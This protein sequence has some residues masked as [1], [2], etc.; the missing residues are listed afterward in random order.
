MK[1]IIVE[2]GKEFKINVRDISENDIFLDV[3]KQAA[4]RVE[5][6][7]TAT[8]NLKANET[9]GDYLNNIIAF[10]GERGQGK[11]SAMISFTEYLLNISK[12]ES[13]MGFG[14]NTKDYKFIKIDTIDPS[15][16]EDMHNILEMIIARMYNKFEEE[17]R[18]NNE[19]VTREQ[20]VKI[21]DMFQRVYENLCLIR[22][23]R[24]LEELEYDYEGSIQKIA[25]IGDST[26][27][28]ENIINLVK[29][30]LEIFAEGADKSFLVIPIDDLDINIK[31][32]YKIAEQI[33]KYLV[34]PNVIIIMAIK[35]EQ[36][37]KCVEKEFREQLSS[38]II[39]KNRIDND[40]PNNMA[41]KYVE[42]LIPDGRKINLP[43][44]RVISQS[45][46]DEIKL[47]YKARV[48][49]KNILESDIRRGIEETLLGYIYDKTKIIFVK[50]RNSVHNIIPNT[51]R[52]VVNLLSVLGKM[53]DLNNDEENINQ[54]ENIKLFEEYFISTWVPNNLDDGNTRIVRELLE[55]N[56]FEKH[57]LIC[58][59]IMDIIE[60][61]TMYTVDKKTPISPLNETF[62]S[63]KNK[64]SKKNTNS[65]RYSL[66]DVVDLLD[67][68]STRYINTQID[69]FIFAIKTIYTILMN[70]IVLTETEKYNVF[71]PNEIYKF[72]G[73][74]IWG[75]KLNN[76]MRDKRGS[77]IYDAK[78]V[79]GNSFPIN[80]R[81][82]NEDMNEDMADLITRITLFSNF[83][84]VDN[85]DVIYS[86]KF[87]SD[88]HQVKKNPVLSIDN[89]FIAPLD[90]RYLHYKSGLN[91]LDYDND[92]YIDE[93]QN[94]FN[95]DLLRQIVINMELSEYIQQYCEEN[96]GIKY[97]V[98][99]ESEY[100]IKFVD[101]VKDA[102]NEVDYINLMEKE[103]ISNGIF[104]TELFK[105]GLA[106]C[107]ALCLSAK[108][109]ESEKTNEKAAK[110]IN[111]VLEGTQ[112]K[113]GDIRLI[114]G[115]CTALYLKNQALNLARNIAYHENTKKIIKFNEETRNKVQE[116]YI[117]SA[118]TIQEFG[119]GHKISPEMFD[120][121]NEVATN[122]RNTIDN[123]NRER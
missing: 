6:I 86:Q 16:F 61:T 42:K 75:Y 24:K 39:A 99:Y 111:T 32:A 67:V 93:I 18:K 101:Y 37:K 63:L 20:K 94:S 40:E 113:I 90:L 103:K 66:G 114:T 115:I 28:Q 11:S 12:S 89:L 8:S 68:L 48:T 88:N 53:P 56:T 83:P 64:F 118:T 87:I 74:S 52:E 26:K 43:E 5:D 36:L 73:G 49:G 92:N 100:F 31:H 23:P 59:R 65:M 82:K 81:L 102:L 104:R 85:Q 4:S 98:N 21:M 7:V 14:Y 44:I 112:E 105:S 60:T 123:L 13:K 10:S 84:N 57:R 106:E 15:T 54:L 109:D 9:H 47:I 97:R 34:I 71:E 25:H 107:F 95:I 46:N 50:P 69:N 17:Y 117:D 30:Y 27:V 91:V 79:L 51:L 2:Q 80:E 116:L 19:F 1:E 22:N 38:L 76:I 120:K 119:N 110:K 72:I 33:R 35:I 41:T 70:K 58:I 29:I 55:A 121:Y 122:I 108:V 62:D 3:Y 78:K 45:G 96:R 77:F